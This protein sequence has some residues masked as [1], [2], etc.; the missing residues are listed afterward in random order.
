M[1]QDFQDY[2]IEQDTKEYYFRSFIV[3]IMALIAF[4]VTFSANSAS[5]S[6]LSASVDKSFAAVTEGLEKKSGLLDVYMDHEKGK[7]YLVLPKADAAG[8][9]GRYLYA[10]Y[11]A[12][13]LGSNP[14]GLDRSAPTGSMIVRFERIAGQMAVFVE[15]MDFRASSPNP[16]EK[17]S[18]ENSF[19]TSMIWTGP[20]VATEAATGKQLIDFT[21]FLTR[22]AVGVTARLSQTGQG[23]FRQD[24]K[25]SFAMTKSVHAFPINLEFDAWVTFT[26]SKPG[27][28]VRATTP[29]PQVVTLKGHTTLM[30]LPDDGYQV[31]GSDH[32]APLM[33][34]SYTDMSAPLDQDTVVRMARRFRL[35]KDASG[36]VIKPIVFYVDHGAPEPIRS[37]LVEG[38]NWWAKSFEAAGFKGGFRA[39]VLPKDVHPMDAR[40]NVINWVH[41]ATRGWSYG[42]AV[43]D[44]R[45][46]ET[47]RG[48]VLLGSL[49][50]RQDIKIFEALAGAGKTGTGAADDPVEMAL[51]R[52]RQLSAHE[53]GHPLGFTHN[54]AASSYGNRESVMDYPAPLVTMQ[55]DQSGLDFSNVYGVGTGTWDDWSVKFLYGDYPSD[56]TEKQ[57]QDQLIAE[58]DKQ[59][60]IFVSDQDS[61]SVASAHPHGA[62]WDNGE[63]AV[64]HLLEVMKVRRHALDKF[65]ADNLRPHESTVALQTKIVPLYLYHRYQLAAAAKSLGGVDFKY[66]RAGDGRPLAQDVGWGE[67]KRA[68]D[69]MLMTLSP[70][71]LDLPDA[72]MMALSPTGSAFGDPQFYREKFAGQSHALF[73]HMQAASVAADMTLTAIMTPERLNRILQ[74]QTRLRGHPGIGG[75][76]NSLTEAIFSPVPRKAARQRQIQVVVLDRYIQKLA[77]QLFNYRVHQP[78]RAAVRY[79][80]TTILERLNN[81]ESIESA[82]LVAQIRDYL[83]RAKT[84]AV[85]MPS[86]PKTPPGSPIGMEAM[87]F[88]PGDTVKTEPC[89]FCDID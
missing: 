22:D 60:L 37:A 68:L 77:D 45:T 81:Q 55:K 53:V 17:T 67:Q 6:S 69:A 21:S 31:R 36:K 51:M 14:V 41:R 71:A 46:G 43:Y 3:T 76:L 50:V 80:L 87:I 24:K 78:V 20:V 8:I 9:S 74:Q 75:V 58:A 70:Q 28:E 26:S 39:E 64:D 27:R 15:N 44:P 88:I 62:V 89:W 86:G 72:V 32:R 48:V 73:D 47:L 35:Q 19:A 30:Q 59:G 2:Q 11:L 84:P 33:T 65:G 23:V 66:R 1:S 42:A 12:A 10:G 61:R 82:A 34:V 52:I 25:R 83:A 29:V 40:Y 49:R 4:L 7:V 38:A 56:M 5:A 79:Q 63:N 13:G 16:A 18:V 54:M 85:K 57:A